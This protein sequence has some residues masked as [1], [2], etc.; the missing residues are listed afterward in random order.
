MPSVAKKIA[1]AAL[2]ACVLLYAVDFGL[3]QIKMSRNNGA[4][5]LGTVTYFYG[6]AMKDGKMEIFTDEPQTETCAHSLFPH[7]GY[8]PC[9]LAARNAVKPI[10]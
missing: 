7:A 1:V 3:F 8:R 9:W 6:A 10:G 5:A 2:S 4:D